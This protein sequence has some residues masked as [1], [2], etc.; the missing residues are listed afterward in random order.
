M[1]PSILTTTVITLP[2]QTVSPAARTEYDAL[3]DLMDKYH[4]Q[5]LNRPGAVTREQARGADT[6]AA[7]LDLALASNRLTE[8][9]VTWERL[10]LRGSDHI[11]ILLS[12]GC[13]IERTSPTRARV[14]SGPLLTIPQWD[15]GDDRIG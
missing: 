9:G 5:L 3:C 10:I 4:L 12:F 1:A 8:L 14:A 7:V 2:Q 15:F 6:C 13:P 11:P